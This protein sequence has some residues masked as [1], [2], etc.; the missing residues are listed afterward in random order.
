MCN[1]IKT[2][3]FDLGGV[4]AYQDLDLLTEEELMLFRVYMNRNDILDKELIDYAHKRMI[5]I[6][7]K[8]YKL[9]SEAILTFEMLNDLKIR[10]SIWTNNI[11]EIDNWFEEVH[12]Y[13]Y[14][15]RENIIN[16]FYIGVDKPNLAFYLRA[17]E[18][19]GDMPQE[20]LFLDDHLENV[21]GA[22]MLEINSK[23]YNGDDSLREVVQFE[24]KKGGYYE[25]N[26]V[27]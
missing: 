17:L 13:Q 4:L 11:Q 8:I 24:I 10:L 16:S 27:R 7:L 19:L 15:K 23:I 5:E 3:A 12:L 9:T 18:L 21:E 25:N 20:I 6:Y 26:S 14:I 1:Q 22:K 2:V